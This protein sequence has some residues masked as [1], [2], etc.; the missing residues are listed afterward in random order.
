MPRIRRRKGM[1]RNGA[2]S[3]KQRFA[4]RRG[5]NGSTSVSVIAAVPSASINSLFSS[6]LLPLHLVSTLTDEIAQKVHYSRYLR[7]LV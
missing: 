1:G 3:G 2:M 6:T 7:V 4:S 5:S